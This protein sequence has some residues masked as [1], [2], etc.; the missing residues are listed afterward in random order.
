M[1]PHQTRAIPKRSSKKPE[2]NR[3]AAEIRKESRQLCDEMELKL[4]ELRAE[5]ERSRLNCKR[6][7]AI[8]LTAFTDRS[9][10]FA[11]RIDEQAAVLHSLPHLELGT[12]SGGGAPS[13]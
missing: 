4:K 6:S 2:L 8:R 13:R 10:P 11:P 3:I 9:E 5:L 7:R 1:Q 12:S